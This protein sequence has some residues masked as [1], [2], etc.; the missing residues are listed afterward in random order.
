MAVDNAIECVTVELQLKSGKNITI[1][2][3]GNVHR[4]LKSNVDTCIEITQ[5]NYNEEDKQH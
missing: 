1:G 4:T 5:H 2:M 3:I